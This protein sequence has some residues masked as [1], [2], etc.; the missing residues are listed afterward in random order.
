MPRDNANLQ[1]VHGID[2]KYVAVSSY[3]GH[4]SSVHVH[5]HGLQSSRGSENS[6]KARCRLRPRGD[7]S[8][9][10]QQPLLTSCEGLLE[11]TVDIV[12]R[13]VHHNLFDR[14]SARISLKV[15]LKF[16]DNTV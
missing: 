14:R 1:I 12:I 5:L 9:A 16:R 13:G 10:F 15:T 4:E 2:L 8:V 7:H 11:T 3:H 6:S